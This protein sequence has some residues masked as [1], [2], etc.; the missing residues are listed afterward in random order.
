MD[1][2]FVSAMIGVLKK[3]GLCADVERT[4]T[5]EEVERRLMCARA[6]GH[7]LCDP[8]PQTFTQV[9][10]TGRLLISRGSR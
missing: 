10:S 7:R 5:P 3:V 8:S 1:C 2:L 6:L 9:V 4:E